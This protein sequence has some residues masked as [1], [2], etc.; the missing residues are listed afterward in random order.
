MLDQIAAV[1]RQHRVTLRVAEEEFGLG[2][3]HQVDAA[4]ALAA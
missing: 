4:A 2:V 3:F 1:P